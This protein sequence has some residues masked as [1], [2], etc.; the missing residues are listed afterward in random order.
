MANKTKVVRVSMYLKKKEGLSQKEFNRYWS[1]VHGPLVR[2]LVEKYGILKYTQVSRYRGRSATAV[3][4]SIQYHT[5]DVLQEKTMSAWPELESSSITP[6]DG[7]AEFIVKDIMDIKKSRDDPIFLDQIIA[8]E[9]KFL[10]RS[11]IGWTIGWEE[12]YVED[13]KIVPDSQV[14]LNAPK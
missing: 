4:L 3:D 14:R 11:G 10:D 6:Y 12:V 7:V 9:A 5:S 2:P 1:E 13:N 8:D